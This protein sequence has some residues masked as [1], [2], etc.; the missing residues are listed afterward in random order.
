MDESIGPSAGPTSGITLYALKEGAAAL[1]IGAAQLASST[2][3]MDKTLVSMVNE[4]L[5]PITGGD[6]YIRSFTS[7]KNVDIQSIQFAMHTSA[8]EIPEV[9]VE[10]VVEE[11]L[12]FFQRILRLFGLY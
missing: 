11:E 9:V 7:V 4:M 2:S 12:N 8:I 6:G 5:E 10:E 3:G 1:S